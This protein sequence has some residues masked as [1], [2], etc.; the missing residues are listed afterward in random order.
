MKMNPSVASVTVAFNAAKV[1]PRQMDALL[2]QTRGLQEMVVVDN[3]S[4]DGTSALLAERY[5]QVTVL[6]MSENVGAGGALAAGI[7]YAALQK[8]HD[9]VWT[10]DDDSVPNNNA[11]EALLEGTQSL[12]SMNGELGVAAS[13][14]IHRE[15]GACYHPLLWRDGLVKPPE[16]LL[17]KPVWFADLV[18]VSG[19][20]V[21]REVVEK[22]GLPRADFFMDF[23]DFEY[24]LRARAR[25]YKI[26]VVTGSQIAHEI[27]DARK[28]RLPGYSRLW[29]DHAP[30]REYYMSRNIAYAAWWLY[31]NRRTKHSVMR[32]LIRHAGGVLLF[33][34]NKLACLRK[35]AQG[36]SD[37]WRAN[38]GIRFR[39][40]QK[41]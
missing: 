28:I 9:W 37:G 35:M 22:I 29:S 6:R 5:P 23:I 39:P 40:C 8:R 12:E 19:C 33:G 14:P 10:F 30:W 32:H 13:L 4:T 31:P 11:L 2:R 18:I 24:C 7:N 38:L 41:E 26:A 15:T 36:F 16:E 17:G 34:A 21:R 27:G 20:M 3:A 25:G 1:L